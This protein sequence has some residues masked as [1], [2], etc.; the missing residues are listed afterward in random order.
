M[1][2]LLLLLIVIMSLTACAQAT[3]EIPIEDFIGHNVQEVYDWCAKLDEGYSCEIVYQENDQYDKDV[4]YDQSVKPGEKLKSE[5]IHFYVSNGITSEIAVPFIT[6]ELSKSDIDAWK[7]VTG[8][9]H[10]EYAYETSD[11]VKK[12]HVIRIEPVNHIKKDTPVTVFLSSGPETP[13]NEPFDIAYGDYIGLTVAEFEKKAKELGLNPHHQESRD[14][15]N[16]DIKFGNIAWHGSGT[17]ERG[18]DFNYGVCIN[19]IVVNPGEYVGKSEDDFIKIAKKMKLNPTHI[20][21]RDSFS[22]SIDRGYIVT[23]GNGVY[24]EGEDFNYGLSYGPAIVQSGYEGASEDAFLDYLSKLTLKGDRNT[25]YSDSVKAGRII[26]YNTGRYS[27]G[28]LVTYYVSLGKEEVYVDVPDFSGSNEEDLL[29]FF[30]NNG[31][32]VGSRSEQSSLIPKGKI[33]KNDHGKIK[34]GSAAS[35]TVSTGPAQRETA[36][37]EAFSTI[38]DE[39][40]F[41]GD[42]ERAEWTMHR[43]LFGR[44][45]MNYEIIPVVYGDIEPGVLLSI[46]IDGEELGDYPV[47]V[48]ID[49]YVECRITSSLE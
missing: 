7:E 13:S 15:Y 16:P 19:S 14:R 38:Y 30:A 33:V 41:K 1:K 9:Q 35:Y 6:E 40:T 20:A 29:N 4:V 39:V 12:N 34:A 5:D 47:N 31:I 11:T 27:S 44:G 28:D 26:A 23:H 3:I 32:L 24:V 21:S 45:F 43:Y 10:L 37:I 25:R 18:E 22:A 46:T 36:I 48:P 42:Y 17:Y 8:L 49:A 2:K